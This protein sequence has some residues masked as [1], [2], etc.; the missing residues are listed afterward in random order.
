[1]KINITCSCWLSLTE[2]MTQMIKPHLC[3]H[4]NHEKIPSLQERLKILAVG[5]RLFLHISEVWEV[6]AMFSLFFLFLLDSHKLLYAFAFHLSEAT[7]CFTTC[8]TA[9]LQQ[10]WW[11]FNDSNPCGF[12][13]FFPF[14]NLFCASFSSRTSKRAIRAEPLLDDKKK[15]KPR[16]S[17][18]LQTPIAIFILVHLL[19]T[20][21]PWIWKDGLAGQSGAN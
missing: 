18:V 19:K 7:A 13:F 5:R 21:N 9:N 3:I 6:K 4:W 2:D 16:A 8:I 14:T 10:L 17:F 11:H 1:M 12:C 20:L 15:K